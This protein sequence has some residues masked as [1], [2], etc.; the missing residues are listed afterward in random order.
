MAKKSKKEEVVKELSHNDKKIAKLISGKRKQRG[1]KN[2]IHT[3]YIL[4]AA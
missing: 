3:G 4:P 2:S 1:R